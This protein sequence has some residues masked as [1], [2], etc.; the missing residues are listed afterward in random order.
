MAIVGCGKV[1]DKHAS[2]IQRIRGCEIVGVC[3]QEELMAAQLAERFGINRY[4]SEVR[5][6]LSTCRPNVVHIT[7]PPASHYS[8]AKQC[9]E[10]GCHV[11][12][13][14]PF[15][16]N[17]E[18][19]KALIN[20]AEINSLKLTVG[21]ETQFMPVARDMRRLIRSGY[22][23][24]E[25]LHM[26]SMYCYEFV[27]E[28]YAKALLGD[29]N[30]WVRG[31]PGGLL[32]NIISHGI[33]KIVEYLPNENV[34]VV[35]RGFTSRFLESIGET[36]IVDEL[37]VI[38]SDDHLTTAYFTF[39]SQLSP[40]QHLFRVYGPKNSLIAD[41]EHQILLKVHNGNYRSYLNQFFPPFAIGMQYARNGFQNIN[42]FLHKDF[43]TEYGIHFLLKSFYQSL[44][45]NTPLPI[46]YRDILLTAK[47][48]DDIFSQIG[49]KE[50]DP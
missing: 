9:L 1:A 50:S 29:S 24:G 36:R 13:E 43:H 23:G 21:H 19:A 28:R 39:S 4:F 49:G 40:S 42:R 12:V 31:L 45:E 32:Q 41:H 18:E 6:M 35:A 37:R 10:A 44:T 7:T 46:S 8:L 47:I 48:M 22:L 25:A 27:D 16:L 14:K 17:S 5:A 2:Q 20:F 3:D 15:T 11:Y 33:G 34:T 30:H 26:E 38:I